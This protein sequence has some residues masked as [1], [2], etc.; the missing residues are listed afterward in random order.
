MTYKSKNQ[1]ML[2]RKGLEGFLTSQ[3]NYTV[4]LLT[5]T[6]SH[7]ENNKI[8]NYRKA[9]ILINSMVNENSK[10]FQ[11]EIRILFDNLKVTI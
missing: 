6:D 10:T 1:N 7:K 2:N 11:N 3:Q 5:I 9:Q 4:L 8:Y